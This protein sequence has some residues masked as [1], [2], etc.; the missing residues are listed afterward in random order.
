MKKNRI[1][2][3]IKKYHLNGLIKQAIWVIDDGTLQVKAI[4]ESKK[5]FCGVTWKN[6]YGFEDTEIGVPDTTEL[7]CYLGAIFSADVSMD[8]VKDA[9][10]NVTTLTF[11]GPGIQAQLVTSAP[12]NLD[13]S[14]IMKNVQA[15]NAAI[16]LDDQFKKWFSKAYSASGTDNSLLAF[17]MSKRTGKLEVVLGHKENSVS[18]RCCFYPTTLENMGVLKDRPNFSARYLKNVLKANPEFKDPILKVSDEGLAS[19]TFLEDDLDSQYQF[20]KVDVD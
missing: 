12:V 1:E 14:P 2:R 10:N 4:T 3:F 15:P 7:L 18:D 13:Q 11:S 17:V 6:F 19:I 9:S 5:L 16:I 8:F 20:F